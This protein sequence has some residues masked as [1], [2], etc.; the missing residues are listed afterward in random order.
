MNIRAKLRCPKCG[1]V[2]GVEMP[3]DACQ[4]FYQCVNCKELLKPKEGECCVFC[5]YANRICPPKQ[6][7]QEGKKAL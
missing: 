5:S 7:E 6:K 3:T 1:Y 2:Q 4:L